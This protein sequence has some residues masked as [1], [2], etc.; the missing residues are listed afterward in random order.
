MHAADHQVVMRSLCFILDLFIW[1]WFSYFGWLGWTPVVCF[2][3]FQ[4]LRDVMIIT[5]QIV[6]IELSDSHVANMKMEIVEY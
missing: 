2:G 4:I 5:K 6:I 1:I 3:L